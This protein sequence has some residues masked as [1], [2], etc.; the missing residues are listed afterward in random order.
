[1]RF[2]K[3][4]SELVGKYIKPKSIIVYES[5]VYP[6]ITEE[7][8]GNILEKISGLKINDDFSLGYSQKIKS[9]DKRHTLKNIVKVVKYQLQN[10]EALEFLKF[11]WKNHNSWSFMRLNQLKLLKQQSN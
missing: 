2:L 7:Y 10:Q 9:G 4:S 1:M 11:L 6:G 3:E 8:C 5:T